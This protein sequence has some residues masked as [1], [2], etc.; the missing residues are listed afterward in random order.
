MSSDQDIGVDGDSSDE[1]KQLDQAPPSA[2]EA[3]FLVGWDG[4][5]DPLNPRSLPVARK[6]VIV[7]VIALGSLLV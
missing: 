5:N 2:R 1:E 7:I 4:D 3:E 6:W